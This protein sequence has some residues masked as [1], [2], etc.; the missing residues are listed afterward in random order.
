VRLEFQRT[1]GRLRIN[2]VWRTF[3]DTLAVFYRL[4]ILHYYDRPVDQLPMRT[5]GN[6]PREIRHDECL[7]PLAREAART[8]R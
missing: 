3:L 6:D 7:T 5:S 4:N 8:Q 1:L 2:A